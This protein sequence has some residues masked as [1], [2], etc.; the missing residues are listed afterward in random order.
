VSKDSVASHQKFK[1]KHKINFPL[2]SDPDLKALKAY[3]AWQK[4][5]MYGKE[6]MGTVRSTF[7]IDEKGTILEVWDKVRVDGH[8]AEV[9][10]A[11]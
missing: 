5:K 2:L 1:E 9:L 10:K 4:K 3:G 6:V 8:V 11:L 7:L